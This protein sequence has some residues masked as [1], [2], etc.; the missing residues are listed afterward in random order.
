[1]ITFNSKELVQNFLSELPERSQEI[2]IGRYGLGNSVKKHTLE[3]IGQKYGITRERVRQIENHSIKNI[4]KSDSFSNSEK[5]FN[6]LLEIIES[7]GGIAAEKHL[8]EHLSN[9]NSEQNHIHF[10]F[11]VGNPFYKEKGDNNFD[12]R[13]YTDKKLAI[14][15][16]KA[17]ENVHNQFEGDQ[18]VTESELL[19]IVR[20]EAR[21][22]KARKEINDEQI[23]KWL[24]I[25]KVINSNPFGEWGLVTSQNIK[26]RGI[27]SYA[28]LVVR[29]NGSPMHFKEVAKKINEHFGKN[30]HTATCHNE[31]IKD[32]RFVLVGRGMY[33]LSEWGYSQGIVRDVVMD[34]LKKKGRM[35]KEEVVEGVLK[36]RYVKENTVIVN[37]QNSDFFKKHKDGTYSVL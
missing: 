23:K 5:Y 16:I 4:I 3:A 27:R 18:L 29:Q 12:T 10:L 30:V 32:Q 36:E 13:W 34:I 6:E 26:I 17:L 2:L 19:E 11:V 37:L 25:S 24:T 9:D 20:R 8:L 28:Y 15:V 21:K 1:M 22:I 33:A 31:L 35:T 7:I 14:E